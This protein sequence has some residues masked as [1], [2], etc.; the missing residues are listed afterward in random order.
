MRD[1]NSRS[2]NSF[3]LLL[4]QTVVSMFSVVLSFHSVS[5]YCPRVLPSTEASYSY[6]LTACLGKSA[7]RLGRRG[8]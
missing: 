7:Q 3:V 6:A 5:Y 1:I 4:V 2:S 8:K